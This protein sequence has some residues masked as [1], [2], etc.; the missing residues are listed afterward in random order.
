VALD[1]RKP[2]ST[3]DQS[4]G[5]KEAASDVNQMSRGNMWLE[6]KQWQKIYLR[7]F[8]LFMGDYFSTHTC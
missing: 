3:E 1:P 8:N 6:R 5:Q 7:N 2:S 4:C